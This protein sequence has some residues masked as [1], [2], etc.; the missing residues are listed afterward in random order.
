MIDLSDLNLTPNDVTIAE[1]VVTI[2]GSA[3]GG[4]DLVITTDDDAI[5]LADVLL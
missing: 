2:D 3:L 1:G 4:D 5:A